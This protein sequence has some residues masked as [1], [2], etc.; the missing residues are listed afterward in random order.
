MTSINSQVKVKPPG[1]IKKTDE[2]KEDEKPVA[3]P[4]IDKSQGADT[5]AK[6]QAFEKEKISSFRD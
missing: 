6:E 4:A 2:K 3:K 5:F 1:A